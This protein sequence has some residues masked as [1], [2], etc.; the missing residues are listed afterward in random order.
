[1]EGRR[2]TVVTGL[3]TEAVMAVMAVGWE[4]EMAQEEAAHPAAVGEMGM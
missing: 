1:M 3:A 2:A 4:A